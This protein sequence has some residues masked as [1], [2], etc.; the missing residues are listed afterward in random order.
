VLS[1]TAGVLGVVLALFI[2]QAVIPIVPV[3]VP[4]IYDIGIDWRVLSFALAASVV[5]AVAAGL[6]PAWKSG[7]PNVNEMLKQ[8]GAGASVSASTRLH[9]VLIAGEIALALVLMTA[10]GLMIRSLTRFMSIDLGFDTRNVL[11]MNLVP[12]ALR[13]NRDLQRQT[14]YYQR[15][16]DSVRSIPGVRH[17][18]IA[19]FLPVTTTS[20]IARMQ[21]VSDAIPAGRHQVMSA[22]ESKFEFSYRKVVSTDYFRTL[23]IPLLAG[24]YFE[25]RDGPLSPCVLILD[26]AQA[27]E[28]FPNENPVGRQLILQEKPPAVCRIVGI[29]ENLR[30]WGISREPEYPLIYQNSAQTQLTAARLILR[31]SIAPEAIIPDLRAALRTIDRDLPFYD[32]K[33]LDDYVAS[34]YSRRT[35]PT[36]L[37]SGFAGVALVLALFGVY[38]TTAYLIR[39]R[40]RE[41]GIRMA[42]GARKVDIIRLFLSHGSRTAIA[43][44]VIGLG[45]AYLM[46]RLLTSLLFETKATDPWTFS[47]V[48]FLLLAAALSASLLPAYAASRIDPVRVLRLE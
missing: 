18:A 17:A 10:S 42:V 48:S 8:G 15:L 39:C 23:E 33:T 31:T 40:V 38:S 21:R 6:L 43:G 27:T 9:S 41:I 46:M 14:V 11:T 24:R 7:R 45:A 32:I 3:Y 1:L 47:V 12:D 35:F 2:L 26:R 25:D 4:R 44:I 13:A 5:T 28:L 20:G 22:G 37:L 29:V 36:V 19:D 30:H 34:K 16:L